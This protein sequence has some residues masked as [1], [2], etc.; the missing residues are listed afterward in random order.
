MQ[1]FMIITKKHQ[2]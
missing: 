2:H 1:A